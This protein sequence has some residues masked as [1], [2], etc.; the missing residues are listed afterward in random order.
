MNK[1]KFIYS[2]RH[3]YFLITIYLLI[4]LFLFKK[5]EAF[6]KKNSSWVAEFKNYLSGKKFNFTNDYFS[7]HVEY[8][9]NLLNKLKIK[10]KKIK[11]LEIGCFEGMST[12]FFL[13]FLSNCKITCVDPFK[14]AEELFQKNFNLVYDNF[15]SNT[16]DFKNRIS[17]HKNTSNSFF[18]INRKKFDIVYIDGNHHY[19]FVLNDLINSFDNLKINGI[20]IMDDFLWKY[21]EDINQNPIGAIK[22]F[23]FDNFFRVKILNINYQFVIQR[24]S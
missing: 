3:R 14:P 1:Y 23:L 20:I 11:V 15:T 8:L 17:L 9:V 18:K 4:R 2:S 16:N 7:H 10:E 12:I 13:N 21:Y 22:K 24:I 5:I 19:D 6:N